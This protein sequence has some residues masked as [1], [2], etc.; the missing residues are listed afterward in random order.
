MERPRRG[1]LRKSAS[2]QPSLPFFR[3][4]LTGRVQAKVSAF[5]SICAFVSISSP[6]VDYGV[7]TL[8]MA[9][10][11]L[12]ARPHPGEPGERGPPAYPS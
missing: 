4:K 10:V 11:S 12:G 3:Q 9:V 6:R 7:R 1:L 8:G 2:R 5:G